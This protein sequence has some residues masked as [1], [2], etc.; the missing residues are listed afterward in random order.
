MVLGLV[1]FSIFIS[2]LKVEIECTLSEFAGDA[3]LGGVADT[4][5][6]CAAIL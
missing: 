5:E 4:P 1:S 6:G 2:D 3:K